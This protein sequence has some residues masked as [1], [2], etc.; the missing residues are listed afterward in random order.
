MI[1]RLV[2]I[3]SV[4]FYKRKKKLL[5]FYKSWLIFSKKIF[6]RCLLFPTLKIKLSVAEIV[7]RIFL[8]VTS[9][10]QINIIDVFHLI[11]KLETVE[12]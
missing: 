8:K 6:S 5:N 4:V 12:L 3:S 9:F 10:L 11:S 1:L 7:D 2:M